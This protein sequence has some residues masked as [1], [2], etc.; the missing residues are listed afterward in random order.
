MLASPPRTRRRP[1]LPPSSR[2][3]RVPRH[4]LDPRGVSPLPGA[5]RAGARPGARSI[6]QRTGTRWRKRTHDN[7]LACGRELALPI[8]GVPDRR[9]RKAMAQSRGGV[10]STYRV[11]RRFERTLA[12]RVDRPAR[13]D[14]LAHGCRFTSY[15]HN[16]WSSTQ[17]P[18]CAASLT[19]TRQLSRRAD[20]LSRACTSRRG[21]ALPEHSARGFCSLQR[22]ADAR[23]TGCA[24]RGVDWWVTAR[25]CA[26]GGLTQNRQATRRDLSHGPT[27]STDG[28]ATA[29]L[30]YA[31]RLPRVTR[32]LQEGLL[33]RNVHLRGRPRVLT[34]SGR[35]VITRG[36]AT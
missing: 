33:R 22:R 11:A 23:I 35:S 16:S 9:W 34:D 21:L 10:C 1:C 18:R 29:A 5:R 19:R 25:H 30:A 15:R 3:I 12:V 6:A 7:R 17:R 24:C 14:R 28:D 20:R 26:A 13:C 36:F 27:E 31:P 2:E 4:R 32:A 8:H